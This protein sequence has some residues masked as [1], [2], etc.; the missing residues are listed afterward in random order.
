M[1]DVYSLNHRDKNNLKYSIMLR[2]LE[3]IS[4]ILMTAPFAYVWLTH[5]SKRTSAPYYF[6]GNWAI[7]ALFVILYLIFARTYNAM[8][9]TLRRI[10]E[11][12]YSQ[13][14]SAVISDFILYIVIL[15][16]TKHWPAVLPMLTALAVQIAFAFL[17]AVLAHRWYFHNYKP[18]RSVIVWELRSGVENLVKQYRLDRHFNIVA[19]PSL[20]ETL[21]DMDGTLSEAQDVFLCG[22]HS[23][24]RNIIMKYCMY[25]GIRT[26]VIPRVGDVIMSSAVPMQLLHLPMLRVDRY[27]PSPEYL[28]IKR[29]ADIVLSAAALIILSPVMLI[30]A[31]VIKA[32]DGGT[33]FYRQTRL[34]KNGKTFQVLKFRSMRMDAEK[35]GVARL[36]TG[37]HDDRITPVGRFIRKVR[38][39]ELPQLINILVGD[40]SLVGP[41]PER[42]EI[43]AEYETELPE[44]ALRLQAKAGLTGYAQVY[45]KYNTTPY[46]KLLMDL[47]YIA[48]PS[49][50]A[51][52]QIIFATI[53][54]LFLPE[55]TEGVE[56]G[57]KTAL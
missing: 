48:K 15:L 10:S 49:V 55:S 44:F 24:D 30:V 12:I 45:G 17:W 56:E 35:D 25:H 1:Y 28:F 41:R 4:A 19:T 23:H 34:T 7:V 37:D 26:Y 51:D 2:I 22:I 50:V 8:Q 42:P 21:Q 47:M 20:K 29:V 11:I 18:Q 16:L 36:S 40:M 6:W 13:S 52:L 3:L 54:I 33:V 39:D 53:K 5:Y 14:L 46:D 32:T 57:K 9:I 31:I 27:N 43:A 38:I